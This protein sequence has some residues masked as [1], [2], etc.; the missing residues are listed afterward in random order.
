MW[1]PP[2]IQKVVRKK[3]TQKGVVL[4]DLENTS[5]KKIHTHIHKIQDTHLDVILQEDGVVVRVNRVEGFRHGGYQPS[6]LNPV[7][8]RHGSVRPLYGL[9]INVVTIQRP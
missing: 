5:A 7:V 4:K 8:H 3:E 2:N 6:A 1:E 9:R